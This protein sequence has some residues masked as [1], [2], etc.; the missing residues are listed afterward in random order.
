MYKYPIRKIFLSFLF[1]AS[2][3]LLLGQNNFQ[4]L[5]PGPDRQT[6]NLGCEP[7]ESDGFYL[8]NIYADNVE[9]TDFGINVSKH[10]PKG[11]V[12]WSNDYMIEDRAFLADFRRL[13]FENIGGDTLVLLG[14]NIDPFGNG[15]GNYLLK[16]EP[17]MGDV[18][19]SGLVINRDSI[20]SISTFPKVIRGTNDEINYL[21]SHRTADGNTWLHLNAFDNTITSKNGKSISPVDNDGLPVISALMDATITADSNMAV[22]C[23]IAGSD[24]IA[25]EIGL[26]SMDTLLDIQRATKYSI[27]SDFIDGFQVFGIAG[28]QDSGTVMAGVYQ[29]TLTTANLSYVFKV[30]SLGDVMWAKNINPIT[31]SSFTLVNS[32]IATSE[33]EI[34]VMGKTADFVTG[35]ISDFGI[36]FDQSGNII[37][38]TSYSSMNSFFIDLGVGVRLLSGDLQSFPD[39]SIL[40]STQGIDF[41]N[42]ILLSPLVI[43]MDIEGGAMCEDTLDVEFVEDLI[44]L[45]DTLLLN[46]DNVIV[47]DTLETE[48]KKY[49]AWDVPVL[50]VLDTFFCPQDPVIA[51]INATTPGASSYLWS[52]GDTVPSITVFEEGEYTVT[53]TIDE[54]VCFELCD[55]S[56]IAVREF[57]EASIDPNLSVPCEVTLTASSTTDIVSVIWSTGDSV[58]RITITEPGAYSVIITD[59][60][61]NTADATVNIGEEVFK[62]DP[63]INKDFSRLCEFKELRL[64]AT[65]NNNIPGESWLWSTGDTT[66]RIDVTEPGTYSVT[67]V[68]ICGNVE[69]VS[70]EVAD[71]DL[72]ISFETEIVVG[73]MNVSSCTIDLK[74]DTS[75]ADFAIISYDW[76]T[77]SS[78]SSTTI[79]QAGSYS[80]TVT[81]ECGT[82]STATVLV[83]DSAFDAAEI[84]VIIE[85][86]NTCPDTLTLDISGNT[87]AIISFEWSTGESGNSI[88]VDTGG[89]YSVTVTNTCAEVVSDTYM[90]IDTIIFPDIFFPF[91]QYHDENKEFKPYLSCPEFF[92]GTNYKLEVFNRFGNRVFESESVGSGWNGDYS[93]SRA[94]AGVYMYY[95]SWTGDGGDRSTQGDVTL[96]R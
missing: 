54:K 47:Q 75:D 33:D 79:D 65:S 84:G 37:R 73:A 63:G 43:R 72:D 52:T 68:D 91:S 44:I 6:Y 48:T 62:L 19:Y 69:T 16:I 64:W 89:D 94:P 9:T 10:D 77:G 2:C 42:G 30:D 78:V 5:F 74:A 25:D 88:I 61:D 11:N 45:K 57:P 49:D 80:V 40:Y 20:I 23:L 12:L 32:T 70:I 7:T 87:N 29:N 59:S 4:R 53:V 92:T 14:L 50:T 56:N 90:T 31:P 24:Q 95:A 17:R 28:T 82:I 81:D 38:Q 93:G 8:L 51:T 26:I 21:G 3:F 66:Q 34:L 22:T 58:S 46:E 86:N 71:G 35:M 18:E 55:T 36:F 27:D 85:S 60:C 41:D 1:S 96:I 13:D 67:I 15:N 39:G 76:N 83:D